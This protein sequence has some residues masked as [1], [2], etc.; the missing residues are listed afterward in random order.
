MF[1]GSEVLTVA[2]RVALPYSSLRVCLVAAGREAVA[3]SPSVSS[4]VLFKLQ[5]LG[6]GEALV[7]ATVE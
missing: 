5:G 6:G 4:K 1:E 2:M 3:S 7:L